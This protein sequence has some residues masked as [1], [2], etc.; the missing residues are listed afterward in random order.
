MPPLRFMLLAL[1]GLVCFPVWGQTAE[2]PPTPEQ[3]RFFETNIRPLFVEHCFKCHGPDKRKA[4]L[5]LDTRDAI[6][7]GGRSGAAVTPERPDSSLLMKA[8]SYRDDEL[9]MPPQGKLPDRQIADLTRWIQ[10]G[11]PFPP[12]AAGS[13]DPSGRDHW[14]FRAPV[15]PAVPAVKNVGWP[16]TPLDR[17]VLAALEAKGLQPAP[18]ADRHTL[19]RRA[20]FDLTGLPPTP[21]ELDTF[22]AD[23]SPDAF[24]RVVDRL[25]AS[26]HYGERWGRHWLDV[27][28]YADSNGLDENV[29]FGN[30]WRYRDYVVACLFQSG[31][32]LRPV[33]AGT[34]GGR[35]ATRRRPGG[36][37]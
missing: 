7:K 3:I 4:S 5:R 1:A 24:A 13:K 9:K 22:L 20:T 21:E 36:P 37:P 10:M 27:A 29:A 33:S 15:D 32:A 23:T 28:R 14:A 16:Q 19:L 30:A 11:V 17:F 18:P 31:Q 26:P 35:S 25:L 2:Q 34:T 8:V 6:L 12:K